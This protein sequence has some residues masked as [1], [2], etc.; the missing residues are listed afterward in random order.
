M[1]MQVSNR[2]SPPAETPRFTALP[3]TRLFDENDKEIEAGS[4]VQGYIAIGS[5]LLPTGYFRDEEKTSKTFRVI[6]GHRYGFTGDMG[7]LEEDGSLTFLGRGSGC[8]NTAGEKVYPEEVEEC[9]K[10]HESIRDCIVVGIADPRFGQRVAAVV[11]LD[12]DI[13]DPQGLIKICCDGVLA[14]YKMPRTV[15]AVNKIKRGPNGKPDLKWAKTLT[16]KEYAS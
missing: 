1:A 11:A 16:E 3:D 8:I 15:V 6:N 9:L 14:A 4:G 7:L 5:A 13:E 2:Q 10:Q 12:K